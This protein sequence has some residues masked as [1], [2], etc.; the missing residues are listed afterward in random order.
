MK[1]EHSAGGVVFRKFSIFNFQ[2]SIEYLL[3]K[4][5]GYHKW[6]LP[7]GLIE[8][9]ETSRK[10]AVREVFEEMGVRARI[11]GEE[12]V[13]TIRYEYWAEMVKGTGGTKSTIGNKQP[14]R[15][16]KVYQENEGFKKAEKKQLVKK[17]VDFYLMEWVSGEPTEHDFEMEEAGWFGFE[18]A[19]EKLAFAD[20]R[21]VLAAARDRIL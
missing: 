17:R 13:K 18:E 20:E 8:A 14:M 16:V 9:G 3:G 4:H 5:S 12:P 19:R 7:K 21:A 2:F 15:R 10:T 1:Q 11:V 6:V